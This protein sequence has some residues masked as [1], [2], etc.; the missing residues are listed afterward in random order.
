MTPKIKRQITDKQALDP[1]Q[2][3]LSGNEWEAE[4][5]ENVATC[6]RLTGREVE[7]VE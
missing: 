3:I 7:D 6:V 4:D 5:L 2:K 1:I